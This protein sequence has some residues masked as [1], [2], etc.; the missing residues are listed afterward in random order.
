MRDTKSRRPLI[1]GFLMPLQLPPPKISAAGGMKETSETSA[2]LLA[3][4]AA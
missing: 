1:A 4:A 3:A 2:R